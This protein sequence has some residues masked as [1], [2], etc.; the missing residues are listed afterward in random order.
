MDDDDDDDKG[1]NDIVMSASNFLLLLFFNP[2]SLTFI[3]V[4]LEKQL[5]ARGR[6][7]VGNTHL[8]V[9]ERSF[10]FQLLAGHANI[11]IFAHIYREKLRCKLTIHGSFSIYP[12]ILYSF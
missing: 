4:L 3:S 7:I 11:E 1:I 9:V 8:L 2:K 12:M 10:H 5:G 6:I